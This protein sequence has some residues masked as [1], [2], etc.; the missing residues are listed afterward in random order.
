ME[1]VYSWGVLHHTGDVRRALTN[2]QMA[3]ADGGIF[4]VAL[5]SADV[6]SD[7]EFWLNVKKEYNQAGPFKRRRMFWWYVWNYVM[8]SKL[9]NLPAA[10]SIRAGHEFL[11]RYSRL[12]GRLANG[13]RA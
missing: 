9:G 11:Y 13:V 8:Y 10:T 3:V 1:F 2:A 12:A 4:Y 5:Y 7:H 6:Q